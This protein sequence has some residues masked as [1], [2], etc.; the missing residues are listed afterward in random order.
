METRTDYLTYIE[1]MQ[2]DSEEATLIFHIDPL[3]DKNKLVYV[4]NKC[5]GYLGYDPDRM[6]DVTIE[7]FFDMTIEGVQRFIQE[8]LLSKNLHEERILHLLDGSSHLFHLV[9]HVFEYGPNALFQIHLRKV[10]DNGYVADLN[11]L[12][13]RINEIDFSKGYIAFLI[14]KNYDALLQTFGHDAIIRINKTILSQISDRFGGRAEILSSSQSF[15][16]GINCQQ[17]DIVE[18]FSGLCRGVRKQIFEDDLNL[19]CDMRIGV[20]TYVD[21]RYSGLHEAKYSLSQVYATDKCVG[22]YELPTGQVMM[23]YVIKNDLPYAIENDEFHVVFQ[24]IYN[25]QRPDLYG[26]EVLIRWNHSKY[27]EIPPSDFIPIAEKTEMITAIDLWMVE[28]ALKD[29]DALNIPGKNHLKINFNISPRDFFDPDFVDSFIDL[30]DN[31]TLSFE[32]V[33]L[34]LTETLNLHPKRSSIQRIKDKGIMVALDDFGTGFSSLSQLKNYHIDFLKIDISFVRDINRNYD[35]TLITNAI[36]ALA[37]NLNISVIAEG[38]ESREQISFLKKRGCEYVQGFS[39]HKP[40]TR[41]NLE[42]SLAK[43]GLEGPK[44]DAGLTYKAYVSAY[45][46]GKIMYVPVDKEGSVKLRSDL[47]NRT[48]GYDVTEL[49]R[50][51]SIVIEALLPSFNQHLEEVAATGNENSFVTELKGLKTSVPARVT[52]VIGDEEDTIDVFLEDYSEKKNQYESIRNIYNRYDLIFRKVNIGLMVYDTDMELQEWNAESVATFGYKRNEVVGKNVFK[53]LMDRH[54]Q[55]QMVSVISKTLDGEETE[56]QIESKHKDGHAMICLWKSIWLKDD[57]E[58]IIGVISWVLDITDRL[59]AQNEL[60]ILSTIVKQEPAPILLT[61]K[62]GTIEFVNEAFT[63]V[64]GYN[65]DEAIGEK[66]SIL[67]SGLQTAE[68]Y[69]S[70]WQT[71]ASGQAWEGEFKNKKK[72]GSYYVTDSRIFPIKDDKGATK[73]Y[74]CIQKDVTKEIEKDNLMMEIN[75]T[76][77]NQE[78]LSMIGQMAAGIIHE[79]NNP[80]SFIDINVHALSDMLSEIDKTEANEDILDELEDLS[81]DLKDGIDS[82]KSIAAGL[83]RFTYKSQSNE[84]T[85]VDLNA[86]IET[87]ATISKNEYKYHCDLVMDFDEIDYAYGDAGKIKQVLLNLIINAVHAIRD[88]EVDNGLISIKTYESGEMVC[89]DIK[90]NGPGIPEAIQE[91]IFESFF[92][93]KKNGKGTGLG[94]SLSKK[95]IEHDHKGTL[96]LKSTLGQG[97]TFTIQLRK[98][99]AVTNS[100]EALEL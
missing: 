54:N 74:C 92:T 30:I 29:F 52:M 63:H 70:L 9:Y 100:Q 7:S 21:N 41:Q 44:N 85:D 23:E 88:S 32:N 69:G 34:E 16:I 66:P 17:R 4:N 96:G 15:V 56:I 47:L 25:I 95:I 10:S 86:E 43:S 37:Q 98:M 64:T 22:N 2:N 6:P 82:I 79:I 24:G 8:K 71:I 60:N 49:D 11:K 20:S 19:L 87:I 53:L 39:F 94:L 67:S 73:Q 72:D 27:G 40:M 31:A 38:V 83:K 46:Y 35:N 61:D 80:L 33:I 76:L 42:N 26:F 48:L 90:D 58:E 65:Y 68:Y 14:I 59:A 55:E 13:S 57:H 12:E 36:L 81:K 91:K 99:S 45:E 97:T 89:C 84:F 50:L 78:R 28:N 77:E 93:T 62:D 18:D 51:Q 5:S 1:N 3:T 75:E